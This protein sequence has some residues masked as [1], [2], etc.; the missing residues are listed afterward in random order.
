MIL[1]NALPR[2][3]NGSY[4]CNV[5]RMI[6]TDTPR[7]S[8]RERL[9]ATTRIRFC[10]LAPSIRRARAERHRARRSSTSDGCL[11]AAGASG[12][13]IPFDGHTI[14]VFVDSMSIGTLDS[15]NNF[16]SDI[17]SLFPGY[18]NTNGAVGAKYFDTAALGNGLHT[19]GWLAKDDAGNTQ[20]IGSRFFKVFNQSV[21]IS[22][23]LGPE[24]NPRRHRRVHSIKG[25]RPQACPSPV[26]WAS[27]A[28]GQRRRHRNSSDLVKAV[29]TQLPWL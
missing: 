21:C 16:R 15:Y 22:L 14:E 19:L 13:F 20:G 26:L 28:D 4:A 10:R 27:R 8:A 12:R 7:C 6:S 9:R 5:Y 29:S 18:A 25:W 3:G 11:R 2:Q 17:Q 1:T 24:P 23:P